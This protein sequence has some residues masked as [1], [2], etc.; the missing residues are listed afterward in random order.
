MK[1]RGQASP[2]RNISLLGGRLRAASVARGAAYS[3]DTRI[4]CKSPAIGGSSDRYADALISRRVGIAPT[5]ITEQG[6]VRAT[7][8]R[9]S[10]ALWT[11][12]PI[13]RGQRCVA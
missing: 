10:F 5:A 3:V 2:E 4:L 11:S 8:R 12:S 1:G 7:A 9:R 13:E 6:N